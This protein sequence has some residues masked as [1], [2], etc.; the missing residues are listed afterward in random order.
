MIEAIY[1]KVIMILKGMSETD[2]SKCYEVYNYEKR[3]F[4]LNTTTQ[5]ISEI[6]QGK[7]IEIIILQHFG[8]IN[9]QLGN[10]IISFYNLFLKFYDD[11]ER[12]N[13]IGDFGSNI[14]EKNESFYNASSK[15]VKERG[16]DKKL[17]IIG[18]IISVITNTTLD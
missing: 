14:L 9:T 16:I 1:D 3:E 12:I 7:S 13:L 8:E 2:E 17:V 15:F 10:C 5:I 11:K 6:Q 18:K 4:V